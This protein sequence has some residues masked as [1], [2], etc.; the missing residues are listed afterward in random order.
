MA[1]AFKTETTTITLTLTQAEADIVSGLVGKC[2][3]FPRTEAEELAQGVWETLKDITSMSFFISLA[4]ETT[5]AP[6]LHLNRI[7]Q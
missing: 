6:T 5:E 1:Q 2:A 3:G 7:R 4:D